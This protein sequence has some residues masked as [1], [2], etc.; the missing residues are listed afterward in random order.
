MI[1]MKDFLRVHGLMTDLDQMIELNWAPM[2]LF[3]IDIKMVYLRDQHWGSHLN[4]SMEFCLDLI[5]L[6]Y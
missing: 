1:P 5:I 6:K 4:L 2:M 3:L